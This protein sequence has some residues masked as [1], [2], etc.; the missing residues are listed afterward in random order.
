M[1]RGVLASCLLLAASAHAESSLQEKFNLKYRDFLAQSSQSVLPLPQLSVADWKRL[2][3]SR[4]LKVVYSEPD[5]FYNNKTYTF[6]MYQAADD[7]SYYLDA[8]GGFW[9]MDELVYGPINGA[10]LP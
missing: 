4:S 7:G 9:G 8:K 10:D 6:T 3:D 5:R 1:F 2:R